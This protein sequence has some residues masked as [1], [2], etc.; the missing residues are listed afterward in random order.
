[1]TPFPIHLS[2][3]TVRNLKN[4]SVT[5]HSG[6]IVLLT[7]VSG[8]GKSS[9]A[10]D[11]IY[12]AGRKRYIATLPTFFSTTQTSLP[13]P[14]VQS[15]QGLSP[16]IAVKQNHFAHHH[17]ATVGSTTEL[18]SHLA[19]LFALDGEARDPETLN[20]LNIQSKEQ[21]LATLQD[22]PE[23]TSLTLLAPLLHKDP[24]GV[25]NYIRQ[26]LTKVSILGESH[27]IYEF[28][29]SGIP[30]DSPA[31]L[32]VDSLIKNESNSARLK[33]SLFS[34]LALGEGSCSV[35]I[36][37]KRHS[38]STQVHL[39]SRTFSPLTPQDFSPTSLQGRCPLCQGSGLHITIQDPHLLNETLSIRENC[40]ALA[41]NCSTYL[42]HTIYQALADAL[43]FSL[44]TP[45]KLLPKHIQNTFLWGDKHLAL[46][47]RLFDPVTGKRSLSY[48]LWKGV[49]NEIADKVR[50]A[51]QP[52]SQL[53][54]GTTC[55][56]CSQCHGSGIHEYASAAS[57]KGKTFSEFQQ[58]PLSEW[59][60]FL[61]SQT[62]SSS[63]KEIL[64]GLCQRLSFLVELGLGY[65]TPNR[66]L[67]TLSGGEQE[68]TALAKHLGAGLRGITYVLDEPSIG[69]HPQDTDKLISMIQK[70]RDQGNTIILVEHDERMISFAD[71]IIDIGPGA[72]IFGGKI[73]FNGTPQDFLSYG[74]SLTAKHLR[75]ELSIAI[76][77]PREK[78]SSWLSL[79]HATTNNLKNISI[80][81]PLQRL[82]TVT[83]VSGSGKSSLINDTLVPA[84]EAFLHSGQLPDTLS[85]EHGTIS[86]LIHIS[87]DLPGRSSRSIPLT[88]IKAF[89]TLRELFASQ[90]HS[91]SL[92]L[93]KSH[94]SFN[95]PQGACTECRGL[96]EISLSEDEPSTTCPECH[97]S[98]YQKHILEV[99][100]RGKNIAEVLAM[101]SYEA[102]TFFSHLPSLYEKLHALNS[103]R[104][105]HLP[106]GRPLSTLSG[107]EIQRLKLAYE[108]LLCSS[109]PTLYV[110]DEPTTGL[111]THDIL[112][113][114]QVL[115]SLT[116]QGHTVIV[117]E[118]NMHVVKVSDHVLEL[119]PEGG[120]KGGYLIASCSPRELIK[121]STP[122]AQ[123]LAPYMSMSSQPPKLPPK[124]PSLKSNQNIFIENAYHHNLK[125]LN[126]SLPNNALI[127]VG[128]AS[129]S[130]KHTLVFDVL[131]ASGNI[132]YA[133]LFPPYIRQE[134]LK[135]TPRPHV[136][137]V[138]GLSPVVAVRKRGTQR[139]SRH[140]LASA[141]DISD[142]LEKLF[143]LF[144]EP[145][146]P[147]TG[148]KLEKLTPQGFIDTLMKNSLDLYV[149]VTAP[150]PPEENLELFLQA[151]RKEGFLK[152]FANGKI[153]DLDDPLSFPLE[154]PALVV[155]HIKISPKNKISLLSA[156]SLSLSLSPTPK[157]YI[158]D[159]DRLHMLP[160]S[161]SWQDSLGISYPEI[162]RDLLSRD[163][164]EGQC[165]QCRGSGK[166]LTFSLHHHKE[167][168]RHYTLEKLLAF[169]IPKSLL[170]STLKALPI[171]QNILIEDLSE[172]DFQNLC[173]GT[174][175]YPGLEELLKEHIS[176]TD[177]LIKPFLISEVCSACEGWGLHDY[178]RN[179][180]INA[181]SL[182]EIY[183]ED[184]TFLKRFLQEI[185][186]DCAKLLI[187]D[188]KTRISFIE[189]VGLDYISLKQTQDTLSEGERYRLHLAKKISSNL[190]D[191]VYL[192]ESPLE[193]LH[194]HDFPLLLALLN[195]LV[196]N[197]NTVIATD[198]GNLLAPYAHHSLYLG[199]NSGPEGG[200]LCSPEETPLPE[201]SIPPVDPSL[202]KLA[203][204]LSIH[205][206][207]NLEVSAPLR[208]VV[209]LAGVSGSGKTSLLLE[210]FYKEALRQKSSSIFS[211]ILIL[212]SHSLP[213]SQ[214]SDISTYFDIAPHLRAFYASLTKAKALGISETM[215][216]TNTKKG[217]CADCLG[218]GYQLID[219]AFYALEKRQCPTCS[220]YRIQ[221]LAQEV[222]YEGK[223]FGQLLHTPISAIA[224]MFPFIRKIQPALQALQQLNL[225]YLPLG[226]KLSSL[227]QSENMSLKIAKNLYLPLKKPTLILMDEISSSLDSL[228]KRKLLIKFH[229]LAASG[230]SI[231]FIEHDIEMLKYANY[232]IELGPKAGKEG[233]KLLFCGPP[234]E[235]P[236]STTSILKNYLRF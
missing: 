1:M 45:W 221:P 101:T 41:G 190:T 49:L 34:A 207:Q 50:Y 90:S 197:H 33:V 152:L 234:K 199:P 96:G 111:H 80:R 186:E 122:T 212:D 98:R 25:Q 59:L 126:L 92:G 116:H 174:P 15:I 121:L 17:H 211:D 150:L 195:T 225:G 167:K 218:M 210:G 73:L 157:L 134:L 230:H 175:Q 31:E 119:G 213:S 66:S 228:R 163:H 145:H 30:D 63:T 9:L 215:F 168:L 162:S 227:S 55:H 202:P 19:L 78:A 108:L 219:R 36:G 12:A 72:G 209:A 151:K 84:V 95:S 138:L 114:I 40:C 194:P 74:T 82:S 67:A 231:F 205:H 8:S 86:R 57:W 156:L 88:F 47:V 35:L 4:L 14:K 153:F 75:N 203:V 26:G 120:Q 39:G 21:I 155:Q 206:I 29:S 229:E 5:F 178:A 24:M 166:L 22:L 79:T 171:P 224:T 139:H 123:C 226:E 6:E 58:L 185:R 201:I 60:A 112:A 13:N 93:T 198:R 125:H 28:L 204:N 89:D 124:T 181:I 192:L 137:K 110:L 176:Y 102:A 32:I 104:L 159:H 42:T 236:S 115:R 106:L 85:F 196:S 62:K 44:D 37:Q 99:T 53:P 188:L 48:K 200:F 193:G 169:L 143:A 191:I 133:E 140:T 43:H 222:T 68:R 3:I 161:Q 148:E 64:E 56:T 208:S 20:T 214:R 170:S 100:Y 223:H 180:R 220:G 118:H 87:R 46:P 54:E 7:G 183:Q 146:S 131:Y 113:L 117:I 103:L 233:G 83:G 51:K 158:H 107:G 142:S 127:S 70:L 187:Q 179:V 65:L 235:L 149:T 189:Q 136:G 94:F 144:G 164:K 81:L 154:D 109:K 61:S 105:D 2:G 77:E 71:R 18:F 132:A 216:S 129:A 91:R 23:N 10:F 177:P 38:F 11:T 69:L 128:G 130:G 135:E 172:K 232:L 165:Q 160:Y 147:I 182:P 141:L 27:P 16:T 52:S 173:L 97:S 76:P 184:T 217:Q